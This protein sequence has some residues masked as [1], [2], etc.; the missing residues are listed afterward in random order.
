MMLGHWEILAIVAVVLLIF[1]PSK[2]PALGRSIGE[3]LGNLRRG[4]KGGG[5][6]GKNGEKKKL[7]QGGDAAEPGSRGGAGS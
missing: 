7:S 5:D 1:G 4:L 2:L 3:G 6:E